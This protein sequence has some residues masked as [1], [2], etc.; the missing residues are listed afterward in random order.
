MALILCHLDSTVQP[1]TFKKSKFF[2][3][4]KAGF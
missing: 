4:S 3:I 2:F 1:I